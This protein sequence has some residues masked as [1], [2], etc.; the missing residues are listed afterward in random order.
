MKP[1]DSKFIFAIGQWNQI[2]DLRSAENSKGCACF[3]AVA[4]LYFASLQCFHK[5]HIVR[6]KTKY[7][8]STF[9]T[10]WTE[11]VLKEKRCQNGI[12][13]AMRSAGKKYSNIA[14]RV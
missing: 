4:T 8:L 1:M 11:V 13:F 14:K 2:K 9:S 3:L 6:E 5:F 10:C 12:G 7:L